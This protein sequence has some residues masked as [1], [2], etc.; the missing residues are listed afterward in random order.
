MGKMVCY[1]QTGDLYPGTPLHFMDFLPFPHP[2]RR[3]EVVATLLQLAD[4]VD[5]PDKWVPDTLPGPAECRHYVTR[6]LYQ[7]A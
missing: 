6:T 3:T 1:L 7:V 4:V 2:V 5:D